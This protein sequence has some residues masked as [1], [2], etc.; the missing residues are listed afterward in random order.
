MPTL[1]D[2]E[3]EALKLDPR[4]R[5][6]LAQRL[7]SSLDALSAAEVEALWLDEADRRAGEFD[8]GEAQTFPA[9]QVLAELRSRLQ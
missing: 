3:N 5:A 6:R 2:L 4:S 1:P 9:E 7:L 8:S